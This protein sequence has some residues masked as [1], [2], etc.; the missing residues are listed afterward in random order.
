MTFFC[1][2]VLFPSYLKLQ[3]V[4]DLAK[5]SAAALDAPTISVN[6]VLLAA[7]AGALRRH[8]IEAH[9]ETAVAVQQ[10]HIVQAVVRN[11]YVS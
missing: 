8:Q 9:G 2:R 7:L 11:K 1:T 6:D 4:K 3:H 10:K 5:R